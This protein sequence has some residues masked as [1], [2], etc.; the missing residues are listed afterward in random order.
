MNPDEPKL[1]HPQ[2]A[3][4]VRIRLGKKLNNEWSPIIYAFARASDGVYSNV[5]DLMK[6]WD[7]IY[8]SVK[9]LSKMSLE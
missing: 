9:K 7:N 3:A 5:D 4:I 2:I 1:E 8:D 6:D